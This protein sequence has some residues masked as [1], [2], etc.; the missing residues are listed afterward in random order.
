MPHI[1]LPQTPNCTAVR[2]IR[3]SCVLGHPEGLDHI[4]MLTTQN[5]CNRSHTLQSPQLYN[6]RHLRNPPKSLFIRLYLNIENPSLS[7]SGKSTD[8]TRRAGAV[9]RRFSQDLQCKGL[10]FPPTGQRIHAPLPTQKLPTVS[11]HFECPCPASNNRTA[12]MRHQL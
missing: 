7:T 9:R 3:V 6:E 4:I 8:R 5:S 11:I 1:F 10:P 2:P 12:K